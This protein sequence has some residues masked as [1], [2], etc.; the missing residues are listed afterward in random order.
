MALAWKIKVLT[1]LNE[2]GRNLFGS[3]KVL[4]TNF[5]RQDT[6]SEENVPSQ[7]AVTRQKL[8]NFIKSVD[9]L[10]LHIYWSL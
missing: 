3:I 6:L 8:A 10:L 9:A 5:D 1:E 7:L 2:I 4:I